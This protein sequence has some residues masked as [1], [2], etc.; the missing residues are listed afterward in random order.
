MQGAL[1]LFILVSLD[2][3]KLGVTDVDCAC[4]CLC[5]CDEWDIYELK[6]FL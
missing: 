4:L 3:G 5:S 2:C 1:Q 6:F